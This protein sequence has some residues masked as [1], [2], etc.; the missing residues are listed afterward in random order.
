[1]STTTPTSSAPDKTFDC[2]FTLELPLALQEAVLDVL[3]AHPQ[4]VRGVTV[5]Q[6]QGMGVQT[7]LV[8]AMEHV[9]GRAR[10]VMVQAL[11]LHSEVP[12]LLQALKLEMRSPEV[13]YWV[14]PVLSSGSL[15]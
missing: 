15:S 10:R 14:T 6:V 13:L 9:Q 2:V 7:K 12:S 8:S 3:L 4:W 5:H 1:M 11:M